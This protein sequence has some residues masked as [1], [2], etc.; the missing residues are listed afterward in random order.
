M[1]DQSREVTDPGSHSLR[2]T[3]RASRFLSETVHAL[4]SPPCPGPP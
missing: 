2:V 3:E 1:W 4:P